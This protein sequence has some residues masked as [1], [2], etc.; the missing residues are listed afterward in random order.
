MAEEKSKLSKVRQLQS[1]VVHILQIFRQRKNRVSS[2]RGSKDVDEKKCD[3]FRV[4]NVSWTAW[5]QGKNLDLRIPAEGTSAMF[6]R[7][8]AIS[9]EIEKHVYFNGSSLREIRKHICLHETLKEF[10]LI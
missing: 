10:A 3:S 8:C 5:R 4:K 6:Q 2:L 7:R 9:D 1:T